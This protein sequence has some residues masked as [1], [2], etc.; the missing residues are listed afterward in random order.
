[1]TLTLTTEGLEGSGAETGPG[2]VAAG[3]GTTSEVTAV[4][5]DVAT[6]GGRYESENWERE[7]ISGQREKPADK[8]SGVGDGEGGPKASGVAENPNEDR[9]RVRGGV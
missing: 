3:G 6:A 2:G 1:M 5:A 4:E 9:Q 7:K 8:S